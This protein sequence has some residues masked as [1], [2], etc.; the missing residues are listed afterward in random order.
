MA[1]CMLGTQDHK[2]D[3]LI[4]RERE[5]NRLINSLEINL[6]P[7]CCFLC[8]VISDLRVFFFQ[9]VPATFKDFTMT[10]C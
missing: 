3:M 7:I 2:T 1:V 6:L 10:L 9:I 4:Y 5:I 8:K